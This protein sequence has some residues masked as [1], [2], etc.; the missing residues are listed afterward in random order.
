MVS[1]PRRAEKLYY[2]DYHQNGLCACGCGR[3]LCG[4]IDLHH[5]LF[6]TKGNRKNYPLFIHSLLNLFAVLHDCHMGRTSAG[7]L[8]FITNYQADKKERILEKKKWISDFVNCK[9]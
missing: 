3:F 1:I 6:D 2:L 8:P 5:A 7:K 4:A 9:G